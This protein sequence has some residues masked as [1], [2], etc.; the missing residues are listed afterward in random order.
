[1]ERKAKLLERIISGQL[2]IQTFSGKY[3]EN[4]VQGAVDEIDERTV[5]MLIC[6][7][8][9]RGWR[10]Q[11]VSAAKAI[12]TH[13][14][15]EEREA[16]GRVEIAVNLLSFYA[17]SGPK[18]RGVE[19]QLATR[20]IGELLEN[21]EPSVVKATLG[22]LSS[23]PNLEIYKQV[24]G[25]LLKDSEELQKEAMKWLELKSGEIAFTGK[26]GEELPEEE[27]DF[28]AKSCVVLEK[29]KSAIDASGKKKAKGVNTRLNLLIGLSFNHIVRR[30]YLQQA[31]AARRERDGAN[32]RDEG[33]AWQVY[34]A[35]ETHL[36]EDLGGLILPPIAKKLRSLKRL[37]H[38]GED[39][40]R[41]VLVCAI[42]TVRRVGMHVKYRGEAL[43][44]LER[45]SLHP[46]AP[47]DVREKARR[48]A[49]ELRSSTRTSLIP[50]IVPSKRRADPAPK[51]EPTRPMRIKSPKRS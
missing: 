36:L 26:E 19:S 22:N 16:D 29:T 10:E 21:A 41:N 2:D 7:C 13:P 14:E 20:A 39:M 51:G 8:M 6:L 5:R 27:A 25:L 18:S 28:I 32:R 15:T 24:C 34:G 47:E 42:D 1:M 49:E 37:E 17:A 38:I 23:R 40:D 44:A 45:T 11:G 43:E 48:A 31:A 50:D 35:Y 4:V 12:V 46:E 3:M 33:V 9:E 30:R